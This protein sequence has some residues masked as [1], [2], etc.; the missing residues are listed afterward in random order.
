MG[1]AATV[2]ECDGT[3]IWVCQ[4]SFGYR[5]RTMLGSAIVLVGDLEVR[6]QAGALVPDFSLMLD[7]FPL[8]SLNALAESILI[9]FTIIINGD[10]DLVALEVHHLTVLA[11]A[12]FRTTHLQELVLARRFEQHIDIA[13]DLLSG[14]PVDLAILLLALARRHRLVVQLLA[15]VPA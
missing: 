6:H 7:S 1:C 4:P 3:T 2:L 10:A 5:A 9:E 13:F 14:G 12:I 15:L 11:V 8:L